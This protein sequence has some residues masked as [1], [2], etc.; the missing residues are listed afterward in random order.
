MEMSEIELEKAG[1]GP[2]GHGTTR[3][4]GVTSS[5]RG[6]NCRFLGR[7]GRENTAN[8]LTVIFRMYKNDAL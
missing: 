2:G 4:H 8:M 6:S 5:T 3:Q 7:I 1:A